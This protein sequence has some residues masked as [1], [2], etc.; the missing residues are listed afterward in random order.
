MF[1]LST[2]KLLAL[3]YEYSYQ[4]TFSCGTG[5][6][7]NQFLNS[8]SSLTYPKWIDEYYKSL[9]TWDIHSNKKLQYWWH[10]PILGNS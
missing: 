6:A 3:V 9:M 7:V 8:Y 4:V 2:F 10:L 1:Q 5:L